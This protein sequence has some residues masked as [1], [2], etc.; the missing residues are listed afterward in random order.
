VSSFGSHSD[1]DRAQREWNDLTMKSRKM[2][3]FCDKLMRLALEL[4]SSGYFVKDKA[5]IGITTDLPNAWSLKTPLPDEH[6]EYIH[7]L[8]QTGH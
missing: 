5:G 3:H 2:D 4:G 1:P 7:L 6:V 8:H